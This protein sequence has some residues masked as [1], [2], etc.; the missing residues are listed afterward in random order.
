MYLSGF[1]CSVVVFCSEWFPNTRYTPQKKPNKYFF[2]FASGFC[3]AVWKRGLTPKF[4]HFLYCYIKLAFF[5]TFY[6][7]GSCFRKLAVTIV[8]DS[9]FFETLSHWASWSNMCIICNCMA[10]LLIEHTLYACISPE[11]VVQMFFSH[12]VH[13]MQNGGFWKTQRRT[14][15]IGNTKILLTD[16]ENKMKAIILDVGTGSSPFYINLVYMVNCFIVF[17]YKRTVMNGTSPRQIPVHIIM[18]LANKYS[19]ILEIF[20]WSCYLLRERRCGRVVKT[21]DRKAIGL[22]PCSGS[23]GLLTLSGGGLT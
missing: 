22:N 8:S 4:S 17:I 2:I 16:L 12:T 15:S 3:F 9:S 10:V 11:S 23:N 20:I 14:K 18:S 19:Y 6:V 1:C 5:L 7:S 13:E 21:P